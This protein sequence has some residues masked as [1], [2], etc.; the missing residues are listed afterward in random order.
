MGTCC[1]SRTD[2]DGNTKGGKASSKSTSGKAGGPKTT[3]TG[4]AVKFNPMD[5]VKNTVTAL[6]NTGKLSTTIVLSNCV[7]LIV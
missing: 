6:V 4:G 3:T 7:R 5:D 2:V 1:S